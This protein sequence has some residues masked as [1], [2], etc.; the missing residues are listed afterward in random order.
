MRDK[1]TRH[2]QAV[3]K[4]LEEAEMSFA[5]LEPQ[6]DRELF[7]RHLRR[8]RQLVEVRAEGSSKPF[9]VSHQHAKAKLRWRFNHVKHG[10]LADVYVDGSWRRYGHIA[11][12]GFYW[13]PTPPQGQIRSALH[14]GLVKY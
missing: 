10:T 14:D 9:F 12:L 4:L 1:L 3:L 5:A 13:E 7:K 2:E 8:L 6:S 11:G